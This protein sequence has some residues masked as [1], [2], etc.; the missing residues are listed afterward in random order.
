MILPN[1]KE[2]YLDD[3]KYLFKYD[4]KDMHSPDVY[5]FWRIHYTNRIKNI[6]DVVLEFSSGKV[7]LEIGCSQANI[8]LLLAEKGFTNVALDINHNFLTYSRMKREFGTMLYVCGDGIQ[9]PFRE[10]VFDIIIAGEILEHIAYPELF[11]KEIKK[12]VKFKGLLIITTPNGSSL[13]SRL[14]TFEEISDHRE[15]IIDMQYGPDGSYHLF[16][17]TFNE[18]KKVIE[19]AN[20]K[21]VK[22]EYQNTIFLNRFSYM[23]Y[24]FFPMNI[25]LLLERLFSKIPFINRYYCQ[26]LFLMVQ[27]EE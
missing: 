14:R 15:E 8:S 10:G 22:A 18:L 24:K 17:F 11:L 27:L 5:S 1:E 16:A 25:V 6:I 20:L 7:V 19:E 21:I 4:I 13:F 12:L 23:F 26:N 2:L 9:P 3:H